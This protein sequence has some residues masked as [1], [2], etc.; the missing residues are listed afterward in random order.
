MQN[1][2]N[3]VLFSCMLIFQQQVIQGAAPDLQLIAGVEQDAL[4][5]ALLAGDGI[6]D[7]DEFW[8]TNVEL[9]LVAETD[10]LG[11]EIT[12]MIARRIKENILVAFL[13]TAAIAQAVIDEIERLHADG[14]DLSVA[15]LPQ[16]IQAALLTLSFL[17]DDETASLSFTYHDMLDQ[18]VPIQEILDQIETIGTEYDENNGEYEPIVIDPRIYGIEQG[19]VFIDHPTHVIPAP[20]IKLSKKAFKRMKRKMS[21]RFR[22]LRTKEIQ[23]KTPIPCTVHA[24]NSACA[25][26][27]E[28]TC[29]ICVAQECTLYR[30]VC[31]ICIGDNILCESCITKITVQAI[32]GKLAFISTGD[33]GPVHIDFSLQLPRCAF[34]NEPYYN[35]AN[36]QMLE[37]ALPIHKRRVLVLETLIK[38]L[39]KIP[40]SERPDILERL[41][42]SSV[43]L[44]D[45]KTHRASGTLLPLHWIALQIYEQTAVMHENIRQ[46]FSNAAVWTR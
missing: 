32:V 5:Q 35:E 6:A 24:A 23:Y 15:P 3:I 39:E 33:A 12:T 30:N 45:I 18:G 37:R 17:H 7:V 20:P 22:Q 36:I 44:R 21:I 40:V 9:P 16:E 28:V 13:P 42:A 19:A 25:D 43:P 34:C 11:I 46:P 29:S 4:I 31:T 26:N 27:S 41:I 14:A 2:K 8:H 1:Y 38:E 10:N